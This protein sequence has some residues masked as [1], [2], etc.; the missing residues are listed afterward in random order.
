MCSPA[1]QSE[2]RANLWGPSGW[3]G[4]SA[5]PPRASSP[6]V[7]NLAPAV[8]H[9]WPFSVPRPLGT[10][11]VLARLRCHESCVHGFDRI[12]WN[13]QIRWFQAS[14]SPDLD[15][16][17][18]LCM[19]V[20]EICRTYME[21]QWR[22]TSFPHTLHSTSKHVTFRFG[23]SQHGPSMQTTGGFP[24]HPPCVRQAK[25][26]VQLAGLLF[27]GF[28]LFLSSQQFRAMS[29]LPNMPA[30]SLKKAFNKQREYV[31]RSRWLE[32]GRSFAE[33]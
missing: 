12:R 7:P 31:Y 14:I 6:P 13:N 22:G 26:L 29:M 23:R 17:M 11:A 10:T 3:C 32:P 21:R 9:G 18:A 25:A 20:Y 19:N 15:Q 16:D 33:A 2:A 8:D 5:I 4:I 27:H 1:E 28:L 30:V 24:S